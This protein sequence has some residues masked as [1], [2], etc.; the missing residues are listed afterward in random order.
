[1]RPQFDDLII[2]EC[3]KTTFQES[4]VPALYVKKWILVGDT[5]QLSPFVE[6]D[7]LAENIANLLLK[8][9]KTTKEYDYLQKEYQ[10]V[11]VLLF[12]LSELYNRNKGL[13]GLVF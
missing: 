7:E 5:R 10:G 1:M 6:I 2:D 11:C 3:S 13:R 4:L 8:D 9:N 12:H